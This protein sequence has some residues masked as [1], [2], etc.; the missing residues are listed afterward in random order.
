MD[1]LFTTTVL[2]VAALTAAALTGALVWAIADNIARASGPRREL[3]QRLA[4][5]PMGAV[6]DRLGGSASHYLHRTQLVDVHRRLRT[7]AGCV[8]AERCER[9]L[10]SGAD[11]S[12]FAF[13]PNFAALRGSAAEYRERHSP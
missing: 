4:S 5:L 10:E 7:C 6:L 1:V 11:G 2:S 8:D 12:A 13:C 3:A 9:L